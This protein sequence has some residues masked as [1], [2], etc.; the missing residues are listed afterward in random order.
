[1]C[2]ATSTWNQGLSVCI[3]DPC[4]HPASTQAP[5]VSS[6]P[7]AQWPNLWSAQQTKRL[8][9]LGSMGIIAFPKMEHFNWLKTL[10]APTTQ[11]LLAFDW[12]P[13]PPKEDLPKDLPTIISFPFSKFWGGNFTVSTVFLNWAALCKRHDS[14]TMDSSLVVN[15]P[16]LTHLPTALVLGKMVPHTVENR[17]WVRDVAQ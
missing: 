11:P 12:M 17:W 8:G 2:Q 15:Q 13:S 9:F 14:Q 5:P 7:Q 10:R 4:K 1:M 3:Q 6:A 16:S